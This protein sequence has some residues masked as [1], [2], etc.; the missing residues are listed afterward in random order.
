MYETIILP[1]VLCGSETWS[2]TLRKK[3]RLKVFENMVMRRI[4]ESTCDE[5]TEECRR[6]HK[7]KNS[8]SILLAK[9]YLGDEIKNNETGVAC[10]ACWG[11]ER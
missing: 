5:V 1:V 7:E 11:E 3:C 6:S 8:L 10:G 9:Y 4:F 2:L